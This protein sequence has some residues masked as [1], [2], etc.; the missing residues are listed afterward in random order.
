MKMYYFLLLLLITGSSYGVQMY[1][2][3]LEN[4][5]EQWSYFDMNSA[6]FKTESFFGFTTNSI[7]VDYKM[8]RDS[9]GRRPTDQPFQIIFLLNPS[10]QAIFTDAAVRINNEWI[11]AGAED[12]FAAEDIYDESVKDIPSFLLREKIRRE[13]DGSE[14][15]YLEIRLGPVYFPRSFA[16]SITFQNQN[17]LDLDAF[18]TAIPV[19]QFC[20]YRETSIPIK[21]LFKDAEFPDNP[22]VPVYTYSGQS[23]SFK[24]NAEDWWEATLLSRNVW[25]ENLLIRWSR[26]F[27]QNPELRVF[28]N[29]GDSFFH[30][31]MLPPLAPVDRKEK[32]I[33]VIY[34][35]GVKTSF[36]RETLYS[37]LQS[38]AERGLAETDS[39]NV[40]LMENLAPV[41][42]YSNFVSANKTNIKSA[43]NG[44]KDAVI[45][46][47]SGL[48]QLLRA[49]KDYFNSRNTNGELWIFTDAAEH[50]KAVSSA[51]DILDI[52]LFKLKVNVQFNIFNCSTYSSDNLYL[53]GRYYSGNDYLYENLARLSGGGIV[54]AKKYQWYTLPRALAEVFMPAIDIVESSPNPSGGFYFNRYDLNNGRTHYPIAVPKIE[55]GRYIGDLPFEIEF[56]GKVDDRLFYKN[57]TQ[58]SAQSGPYDHNLEILWHGHYILDLLK[59]PQSNSTITQIGDLSKQQKILSPYC[60]FV[61]PSANGYCGFVRLTQVSLAVEAEPQDGTLSSEFVNMTAFPNPF[62]SQT[63]L[64]IELSP[65]PGIHQ[66]LFEIVDMLGRT[67]TQIEVPVSPEDRNITFIWDG[68]N[69]DGLP[70]GTGIY[71][72]RCTFG[73]I[74]H[75]VKLTLVK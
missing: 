30:L 72:V 3:G 43:F 52:S 12:V 22:P 71:F 24:K 53:N 55:L 14:T 17:E 20:F 2:V 51:N 59:Q 23:L 73:Q 1:A 11:N 44:M 62:N 25:Y 61:V 39:I 9:W 5:G 64:K 40:L 8:I 54:N 50:C 16:F 75:I 19:D 36:D 56:Y 74:Y 41:T 6:E 10:E 15:R 68:K 34:D 47:I 49:A 42:L 66:A 4:P 33:L 26:P 60:S 48:P 7:T 27:T 35:L 57:K 45:P 70:V 67:V 58:I 46:E 13:W 32:K 38:V 31:L 65:Q 18:L 21:V 63:T 69:Q 37:S 28:E 29:H